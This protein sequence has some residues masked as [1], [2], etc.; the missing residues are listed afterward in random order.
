MGIIGQK[1]M[2]S[3]RELNIDEIE[4]VKGAFIGTV[5]RFVVKAAKSKPAQRVGAAT[6]GYEAG[7]RVGEMVGSS[8]GN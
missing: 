7:S 1:E 6:A 2:C 4:A 5:V 8:E 3:S